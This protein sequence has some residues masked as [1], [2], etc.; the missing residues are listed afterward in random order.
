MFSWY[1]PEVCMLGMRKKQCSVVIH[2]WV[3]FCFRCIVLYEPSKSEPKSLDSWG[4]FYQRVRQLLLQACTRTLG[5]YEDRM[6]A[7]REKR[8]EAGWSFV[9]YFLVQV[10]LKL[11]EFM[12]FRMPAG[13]INNLSYT[14][15][16]MF[17][18]FCAL[19]CYLKQVDLNIWLVNPWH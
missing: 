1:K 14:C 18:Y 19:Y 4:N 11:E 7:F 10:S 8:N 5:K 6:R 12:L 3:E 17:M 2:C 9:E 16:Y 13:S 15:Y